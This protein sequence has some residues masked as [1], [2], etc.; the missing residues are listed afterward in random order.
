MLGSI[1]LKYPPPVTREPCDA[2]TRPG[3]FTR[4]L[5]AV[6]ALAPLALSDSLS[7]RTPGRALS[8]DLSP[9]AQGHDH[10]T[11]VF[12]ITHHMHMYM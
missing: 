1:M 2:K 11:C 7:D 10:V 5:T 9:P 8:A 12:V 3:S 6:R 4:G